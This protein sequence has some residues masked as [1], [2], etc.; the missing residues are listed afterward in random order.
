[1]CKYEKLYYEATTD[2]EQTRFSDIH[3]NIRFWIKEIKED[4]RLRALQKINDSDDWKKEY[5]CKFRGF[6]KDEANT[7]YM[8]LDKIYKSLGVNINNI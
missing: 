1:M 3:Y 2:K 8:N 5:E 7:Y 4:M 6:T